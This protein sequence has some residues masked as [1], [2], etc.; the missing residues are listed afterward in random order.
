M[1]PVLRGLTAVTLLA[2]AA[3]ACTLREAPCLAQAEASTMLQMVD[4]VRTDLDC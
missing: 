4:H 3:C 2:F 1:P